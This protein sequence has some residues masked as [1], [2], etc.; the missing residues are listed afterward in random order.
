MIVPPG[1]IVVTG[2]V[3]TAE[4]VFPCDH[5][6]PMSVADLK[7]KVDRQSHIGKGEAYPVPI[8]KW[9]DGRFHLWD[10]RHRYIAALMLGRRHMLVGW[11]EALP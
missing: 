6:A 8:G 5:E 7:E 11:V 2:Y 3:P 9:K 10:G 1:H 4:I